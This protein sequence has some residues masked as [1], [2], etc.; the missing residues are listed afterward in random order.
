VI[1]RHQQTAAR[2]IG[3]EFLV[4][5]L[6]MRAAPGRWNGAAAER[7][8]DMIEFVEIVKTMK[9]RGDACG[10]SGKEKTPVDFHNFLLSLLRGCEQ[11]SKRQ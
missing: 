2:S 1:G 7:R 3:E 8:D 9:M 10:I 4:R 6:V 11:Y 5:K